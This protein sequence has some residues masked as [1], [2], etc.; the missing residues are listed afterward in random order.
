MPGWTKWLMRAAFGGLLAFELANA[1]RFVS[2][3]VEYTWLGLVLT[4]AFVWG[5]LELGAR[6]VRTL[7]RDLHW[8][9]W[10]VALVSTY[11]DAIGDMLH[12]YGRCG[13]YDQVAH[14]LGAAAVTT[15][16]LALVNA[17]RRGR[18]FTMPDFAMAVGMASLLSIV[19]EVEEYLED[20]FLFSSRLGDG[21][22]TANDLLM[23][24]VGSLA[25][26]AVVWWAQRIRRST[27]RRAR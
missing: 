24:L 17:A 15:V 5:A 11:F 9:V 23:D 20:S 22:D 18:T 13:W 25:V 19:Y 1:L 26:I 2:L 3:P 4:S 8:G 10:T 12:L 6:Y 27:V 21:P 14:V 7:G 16:V